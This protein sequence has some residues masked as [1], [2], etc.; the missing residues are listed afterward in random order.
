MINRNTHI[1][2][3]SAHKEICNY[4]CSVCKTTCLQTCEVTAQKKEKIE[5]K[6]SGDLQN[7]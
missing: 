1:V 4:H 2:V 5:R 6:R 3:I 7:H